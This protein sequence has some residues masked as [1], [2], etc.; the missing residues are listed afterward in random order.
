[1]IPRRQFFQN[2]TTASLFYLLP[3]SLSCSKKRLSSGTFYLNSILDILKKIRSKEPNSIREAS[4]IFADTIISRNRCFIY[5]ADSPVAAYLS[6]SLPGLPP[7]FV[8]LRSE[9]MAETVRDGDALL[10]IST[11]EIPETA[12]KKAAHIVGITSPVVFYGRGD[13][14]PEKPADKS[15]LRNI[16]GV[17]IHS[18]LPE[19]DGLV[20]LPEYHSSGILPGSVPALLAVITA[21]AGETY[22]RSGGIGLTGS[23]PP[24]DA[25]SFLDILLERI[26]RLDDFKEKISNAGDLAA[27]RILAGGRLWIYETQ[28]TLGKEI[29]GSKAGVPLFAQ[30]ITRESISRGSLRTGDVLVFGALRS[31][32]TDDLSVMR[33]ARKITDNIISL[34]PHEKTGGYRI[35]KESAVS[36]DN[37]SYETDGILTFDNGARRFM[38]TGAIINS[39]LLWMLLGETADRLIHAGE[40]PSFTE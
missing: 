19:R 23:S 38:T 5:T 31:N 15:Q 24:E 9:A 33:M 14:R 21:V 20:K 28:G 1:M 8:P 39:V 26:G 22:R 36:L 32:D 29:T 12:G 27:E 40:I 7:V 16:S 18:Y 10:T 3:I 4:N 34:C 37:L 35:F 25:L 13:K 30:S 6:G 17:L 2:I 11:G